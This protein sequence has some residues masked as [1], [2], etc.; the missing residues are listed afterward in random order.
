MNKILTSVVVG[1]ALACSNLANAQTPS[2]VESKPTTV[3]KGEGFNVFKAVR[4]GGRG[5]TNIATCPFE[6]PNQ[7]VKEAKR[8]DTFG[9]ALG[10]YV[11]GIP[12]GCGWMLYR[13]G[14]GLWDFLTGPFPTPTYEK[15]Y[16]EPEFLFPQDPYTPQ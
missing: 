3:Q 1:A 4:K 12:I 10:G 14:T 8:H 9:G 5:L 6:I 15:S 11:T 16:I 7:M 13:C 2:P